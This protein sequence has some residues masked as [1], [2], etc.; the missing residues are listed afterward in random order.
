MVTV[1]GSSESITNL[2]CLPCVLQI[3][4]D[5][6][7]DSG[8]EQVEDVM[9]SQADADLPS[10]SDGSNVSDLDDASDVSNEDSDED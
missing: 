5:E 1:A 4:H 2:L 10:D 9:T 8:E 3:Y 7:D 6:S